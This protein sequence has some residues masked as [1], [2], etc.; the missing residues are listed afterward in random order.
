MHCTENK[1]AGNPQPTAICLETV[2]SEDRAEKLPQCWKKSI[3]RTYDHH[4][5]HVHLV[6]ICA[7]GNQVTCMANCNVPWSS[8]HDMWPFFIDSWQ[9][10]APWKNGFAF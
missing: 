2:Q 7:L 1:I 6:S 3:P 9:K 4:P 8:D 10:G 5:P